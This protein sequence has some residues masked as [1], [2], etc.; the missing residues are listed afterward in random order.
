MGE[1]SET[2]VDIQQQQPLEDDG[3]TSWNPVK[4]FFLMLALGSQYIC[5]MLFIVGA[6]VYSRSIAAV[7]GG[8]AISS[9][10]SACVVI[11]PAAFVLPVAQAA[12]YFGRKWL[13]VVPTF[14]GFIGSIVVAKASTMQMAI[15]G[16]ALGGVAF[17]PQPLLHAVASEVMPRKYRSYAQAALNTSI[18]IGSMLSLVIGGALTENNPAGFRTYWYICAGIFVVS[19]VLLA[20]LY[21]PA[22]RDLQV[23][24]TLSQKL[25]SLD[26]MGYFLFD[27]GL[28]LF[29][30]GL[31][32]SQNPFSWQNA[33][34]VAP[35]AIGCAILVA[36][37]VYEWKIKK[38]GLFHHNL[39]KH[40]NFVITLVGVWIEGFAFMAANVY[41]PYS[42]E[43][44]EAGKVSSFRVLLCYTVA[45]A[46]LLVAAFGMGA[47]I[48]YTRRVRIQ[49][50]VSFIGF[51]I[52][53]VLMATMHADEPES[54]FW[55]FICFYG[56]GLGS[57]VIT[58]YTTAQLSTPP[59]LIS[60]TSGLLGSIRSVGGSVGVAVHTAIFTNG[61]TAN[62]FPKVT[63]AV[64]PLG[65]SQETVAP[66]IAALQAGNAAALAKLPGVTGQ[67]IA[68]A[69]LALKKAYLVGFRNVFIC[70]AAFA[71]F[72][73]ILAFFLIDP[74]DQFNARID[75][76][77]EGTDFVRD[78][79]EK[80]AHEGEHVET[81]EPREVT[82]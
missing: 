10:P 17:G 52:F 53:F 5:Q 44:I 26:W 4:V 31:S 51:L 18:S 50:M 23:L 8:A 39:F 9:W 80:R 81:I 58:L 65:V 73:I 13:L 35:F 7:V 66:L 75:A 82:G 29:C 68:A 70:G 56:L 37:F 78:I 69:G 49:A 67:V 74:K 3:P 76:P 11:V 60:L 45:F 59:E 61:L 14:V 19:T 16:F 12:D 20:T 57:C 25:K 28:V 6:G 46:F 21:N 15:V 62:L 63:A 24:L 32:Y 2:N 33:H 54:H 43:I 30:L 71:F 47:W 1:S 34:V 41:F 42:M 22:P 27:A 77:L 36:L 55:G 38:D 48:Y 64:V 72:G 79:E 40:R